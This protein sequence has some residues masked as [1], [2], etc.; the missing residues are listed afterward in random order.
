MGKLAATVGLA[1][2]LFGAVADR[3]GTPDYTYVA[4]PQY[5]G[6]AWRNGHERFPGGATVMLVTAQGQR[7]LAADFYASTDPAV[8]F[9]GLRILFAGKRTTAGPWQIWEV[10][11]AGGAPRQLTTADSDCIRPLY[12][13]DGRVVYTRVF[14]KGSEIQ[15]VPLSGTATPEAL[16]FVPGW[17]LTDDVL[18]DGRILFETNGDLYTVY[19]DGTGVETIRCDHGPQRANGHQV[20]SGDV[21]F[22]VGKRLAR[23]TPALAEQ[24][25]VPQPNLEAAGPGAELSADRWLIPLRSGPARPFHLYD[26]NKSSGQRVELNPGAPGNAVEP[27]VVSSRVPPRD[28]PSAR[29]P[30]RTTGNLLCLNAHESRTPITGDIATVRI[31]TQDAA[32][33][34]VLLGQ[35]VVEADGSFYV[36][37]PADRPLRMELVGRSGAVT[38]AE[39]NWFWMRPSEQRICVGCHAGPERSPE[40]R[41]PETLNRTTV[42]VNMTAI[43]GSTK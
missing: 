19:P 11:V 29:V 14:E 8:S 22:N 3:P 28:F 41:V 9:D 42:P 15:I 31:F 39:K 34:S 23:F 16:T 12:L 13:P 35:T 1:L 18:H 20:A 2:A 21:I 6:A 40:N 38:R 36:Q 43:P 25:D 10:A 7:K 32:G 17:Y 33:S 24:T 30:T 37:V 26:W 27:V 5:D 4:A